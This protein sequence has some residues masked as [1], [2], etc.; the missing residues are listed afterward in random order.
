MLI[1]LKAAYVNVGGGRRGFSMLIV[2]ENLF[3]YY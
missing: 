1:V 2:P 3:S